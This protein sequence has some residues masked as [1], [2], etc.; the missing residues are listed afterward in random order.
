MRDLNSLIRDKL[1]AA[2]VALGVYYLKSIAGEITEISKTLAVAV[3][4]LEDHERR[5]ELL[6]HHEARS[7]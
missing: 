1:L 3:A 2:L 4:R 7:E 5:L 6:E